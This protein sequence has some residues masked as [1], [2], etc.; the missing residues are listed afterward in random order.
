M[1][2]ENERGGDIGI[3][4]DRSS[5]GIFEPLIFIYVKDP[6]SVG[7]PMLFFTEFFSVFSTS[8]RGMTVENYESTGT[9]FYI[10]PLFLFPLFIFLPERHQLVF[11]LPLA[12]GG[13]F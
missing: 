8:S 2:S 12:G 6:L 3:K 13:I 7:P 4:N 9:F 5:F 10:F 1:F 11:P